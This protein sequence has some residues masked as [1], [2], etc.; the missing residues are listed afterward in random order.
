MDPVKKIMAVFLAAAVFFF[1]LRLIHLA[2]EDAAVSPAAD[3][4][5]LQ[6]V[7]DYG[8]I[9]SERCLANLDE[10]GEAGLDLVLCYTSGSRKNDAAEFKAYLDRAKDN[11]LQVI[12]D[13]NELVGDPDASSRAVQVVRMVK[14]HPATWGYY[15]GDENIPEQAAEVREMSAAVHA[16]D[17]G[18]PRLY[19]GNYTSDALTPFSDS[20][21]Y[22]GLDVYPIG[23]G[24]DSEEMVSEVGITARELGIYNAMHG[25]KTVMVLQAFDWT[26]EPREAPL[27][28]R[29][30]RP[31]SRLEM[32][33]MRDLAIAE[34]E[35]EIIL[36]FSYYHLEKDEGLWEDF[37]WAATGDKE[38]IRRN[39]NKN[40]NIQT[41]TQA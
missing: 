21:E 2:V 25:K 41:K 31:P 6:G 4:L 32:R 19:V 40:G 35:P 3:A 24:K 12:W 9:S 22:L 5:P 34:A 17:P 30:K 36:W 15:V 14:D 27:S 1:A 20:A 7:Y 16:A 26:D 23:S 10:I 29:H 37:I 13:F 11:R 28:W 38:D 18:H 39:K 8:N 33:R